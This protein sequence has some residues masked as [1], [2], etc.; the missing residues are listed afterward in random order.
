MLE[1]RI[2]KVCSVA[3]EISRS[4]F[5]HFEWKIG[6][7]IAK[8]LLR[9]RD[10][11]I[12]ETKVSFIIEY[13]GKFK[14]LIDDFWQKKN[15]H[16][17][18]TSLRLFLLKHL[19]KPLTDA[20]NYIIYSDGTSQIGIRGIILCNEHKRLITT[21]LDDNAFRPGKVQVFFHIV[22]EFR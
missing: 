4:T 18:R 3:F 15:L 1:G 17:L 5:P 20:F 9:V 12:F 19:R 13:L 11:C 10:S 14:E 7:N 6:L 2:E 21:T 8:Q 22:A 16:K